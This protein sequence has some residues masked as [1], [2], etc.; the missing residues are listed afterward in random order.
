MV[1]QDY[2]KSITTPASAAEAF[3]KISDVRTWWTP[4]IKGSANH[5]NDVFSMFTEKDTVTLQVVEV[6]PNKKWVWLVTD[7]QMSW[8]QDP[9][10]WKN[11]RIVFEIS[12]E[13]Q[14]TRID[15]THV[16]L[17]PEVECYNVCEP[18]WDR[19]LKTLAAWL[20]TGIAP[21]AR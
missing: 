21:L 18:G 9:T 16:G 15:M 11:T 5:L 19:H 8:L 13:G 2:H 17:V 20:E 14:Q 1:A 3:T 7:C 10:E 4:N 6:V 12:E